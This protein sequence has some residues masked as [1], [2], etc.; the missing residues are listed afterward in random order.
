MS[1][2]AS[3]PA[4]V[5]TTISIAGFKDIYQVP[6]VEQ[7]LNGLQ[8]LGSGANE[9]LRATYVRMIKFR[10]LDRKALASELDH[11]D[12]RRAQRL[13]GAAS[14]VLQPIQRLFDARHLVDVLESGDRDRGFHR[15]GKRSDFTHRS[16]LVRGL[17]API[18]RSAPCR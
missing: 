6:R 2:V 14:Q 9:A 18:G 7:A 8:D 11:P 15:G 4:P 1:E 10:G 3:L 16:I 12:V 5:K 13:V 17:I